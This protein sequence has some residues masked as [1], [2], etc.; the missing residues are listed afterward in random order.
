MNRAE[1]A[2]RDR[3][4]PVPKQ[5]ELS[6]GTAYQICNGCTVTVQI[7]GTEDI[8]EKVKGYFQTYWNVEP[9][10]AVTGDSPVKNTEDYTIRITDGALKVSASGLTGVMNAFKT[11]RQLAEVRRGTVK[12]SGYQLPQC[13]IEDAPAMAFRGI[14]LCIFPETPLWDIEKQIRLAAYHKFNYAVI[15]PWGLFPFE[16]HPEICWAHQKLDKAE[17]KRLIHL[18]RELGITLIPQLNLLGHA[19]CARAITGKHSV[20]DFNPELQP[21]FEPAGW[22]WCLSNQEVRRIQTDLVLELYDF[23]E[24][25][26]YFHIGCDE[27]YDAGSCSECG[28][29]AL[30]DL[31][32]DHILYF[33]DL[34]KEHGVRIIM[35]HDM[36]L[37]IGDKRWKGYVACGRP[38][39]ELGE[40]YREL[41]RD[42]IIADWQYWYPGKEDG[43]GP[44]WATSKFFKSENFDVLVCPWLDN[45]TTTGL[46]KMA[47]QEKLMG[48][49]ETTWHISHDQYFCN[50]YGTAAESAWNPGERTG[51]REAVAYHLRQIQ[52]DMDL[53]EYEKFGFS[54]Y[55]VDPGHHPHPLT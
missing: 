48:M 25:P 20:L 32:R 40:L 2:I 53:K 37:T 50:I 52:W 1:S 36:L 35:W 30:K 34:M 28:K 33:Y 31:V 49:L 54:Q 42:I 14:H 41:P 7:S 11:L 55:Q 15:E 6:G 22:S 12:I 19:T 45:Q 4:I 16:S 43:S 23:F 13:T 10:L 5:M 8:A 9:A 39:Q 44:D 17:L 38:D 51:T 24:H 46:G 3:L 47:A 29:Y 27:A 26:P 21:L 18:G